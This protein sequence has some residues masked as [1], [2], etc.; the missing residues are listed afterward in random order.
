MTWTNEKDWFER[1]FALNG[2]PF[3]RGGPSEKRGGK[4]DPLG[5]PVSIAECLAHYPLLSLGKRFLQYDYALHAYDARATREMN[6]H[7][8]L[9]GKVP[10]P[11]GFDTDRDAKTSENNAPPTRAAFFAKLTPNDLKSA[12]DYSLSQRRAGH[13][14]AD[15]RPLPPPLPPSARTE[16]AT[17]FIKSMRTMCA[18]A[19]HT[20]EHT[21]RAKD[22]DFA[23]ANTRGKAT[24]WYVPTAASLS[25]QLTCLHVYLLR[26]TFTP[27]SLNSLRIRE[28]VGGWTPGQRALPVVK[29][30]RFLRFANFPGAAARTFLETL[31]AVIYYVLGWD[32]AEG[33]PLRRVVPE[34]VPNELGGLLGVTRSFTGAVETQG[35]GTLHIHILVWVAGHASLQQRMR[36]WERTHRFA[37]GKCVLPPAPSD[38][39]QALMQLV[40]Q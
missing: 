7:Q 25:A 24:Y 36:Q 4:K 8:Q 10:A 27:S 16:V 17:A 31:N 29:D 2:F 18:Q 35:R 15:A 9:R 30:Q 33:R 23:V 32:M 6:A 22:K 5:V 11:N 40:A 1:A 37:Q 13:F 38:G 39:E 14:N 34:Q 21:Y 20:T 3:G 26:L 19:E 12:A 28:L